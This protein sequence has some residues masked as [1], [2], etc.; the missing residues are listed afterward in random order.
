MMIRYGNL[1]RE[2]M[3]IRN[4]SDSKVFVYVKFPLQ[5]KFHP[6]IKLQE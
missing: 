3:R 1:F 6:P 5:V 4:V 2:Q